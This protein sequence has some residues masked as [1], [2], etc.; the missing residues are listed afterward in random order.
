LSEGIFVVVVLAIAT[1]YYLL[2]DEHRTHTSEIIALWSAVLLFVVYGI[3]KFGG[4]L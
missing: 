4:V 2:Q 3:L 1:A